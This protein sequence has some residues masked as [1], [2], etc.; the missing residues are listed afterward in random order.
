VYFHA[1][2][3]SYDDFEGNFGVKHHHDSLDTDQQAEN[4]ASGAENCLYFRERLAGYDLT[5]SMQAGGL[6]GG[7]SCFVQG[8][9]VNHQML[10]GCVEGTSWGYDQ[11]YNGGAGGYLAIYNSFVQYTYPSYP[12]C[13]GGDKITCIY[14]LDPLTNAW[15]ISTGA[16]NTLIRIDNWNTVDSGVHSDEILSAGQA[17]PTNFAPTNGMNWSGATFPPFGPDGV[18]SNQ[19]NYSSY[20]LLPSGIRYTNNI[21]HGVYPPGDN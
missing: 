20:I 12:C 11:Y 1:N 13:Y 19:T 15:A 21:A 9:G 4:V 5:N 8:V 17:L 18:I 14:T 2:F 10:V 3:S 16:T 6:N 7:L